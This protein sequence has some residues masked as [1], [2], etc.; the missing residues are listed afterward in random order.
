MQLHDGGFVPRSMN[1]MLSKKGNFRY[2]DDD[3]NYLALDDR[4]TIKMERITNDVAR[5]YVVDA[6]NVQ[7][8]FPANVT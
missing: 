7:Q 1:G 3:V 4:L 5:V 6:Q 2:N 8:P